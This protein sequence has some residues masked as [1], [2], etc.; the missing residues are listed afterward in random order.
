MERS[1]GNLI[2]KS[3]P[4]KFLLLLK[5]ITL[6]FL[7]IGYKMHGDGGSKRRERRLREV[8]RGNWRSSEMW[9]SRSN[10]NLEGLQT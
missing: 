10:T 8:E 1:L 9:R 3:K 6:N 7:S 4:E 5:P 2:V